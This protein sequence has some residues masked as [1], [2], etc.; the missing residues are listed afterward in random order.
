MDMAVRVPRRKQVVKQIR[1]T[2][3][4]LPNLSKHLPL[5]VPKPLSLGQPDK[6]FPWEWSICQWLDGETP[7]PQNITD[8]DGAAVALAEFIAALQRIE[9][10]DGPQPGE[11][12]FFRGVSL[13]QR[14]DIVRSS[15]IQLGDRINSAIVTEA[16]TSDRNAPEFHEAPVWVHGDIHAGNLLVRDGRISAVIDFGGLAV[17]DPAV[18]LIVAWN[19]LPP[20]SRELFRHKLKVSDE[21][22]A[23]GRGWALSIALVALPYYW[24]TNPVIVSTS[25]RVIAQ[26]LTDHGYK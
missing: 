12:N 14:D 2:H 26:V 23:R 7:S 15:I 8:M 21:T 5:E 6:N 25:K 22:W 16:W 3:K 18:D 24:N 17:G 1:K 11:H 19:M 10:K 13:S 20:P 4:W 9:T